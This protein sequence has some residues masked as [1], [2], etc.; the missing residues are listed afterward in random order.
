MQRQKK[1]A[2]SLISRGF[3]RLDILAEFV[4]RQTVKEL[5]LIT[6]PL[7]I[8]NIQKRMANIEQKSYNIPSRNNLIIFKMENV[9]RET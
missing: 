7:K 2:G 8:N 5:V 3:P 9:S 6:S 1:T 4:Y